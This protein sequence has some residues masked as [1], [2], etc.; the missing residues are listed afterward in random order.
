MRLGSVIVSRGVLSTALVATMFATGSIG[1]SPRLDVGSDVLWVALFEGNNLNEWTGVEGGG[2]GVS[3]TPPDMV[4]V[5]TERPHR[6]GFAAKLTIDAGSDGVQQNAGLVRKGSLPEAAY[7]SAWYYLPRTVAV[8]GF[9][10]VFKFRQRSNADDP[11]SERELFDLD[12]VQAPGGEMMLELY[13]HRVAAAAPL[14]DPSPIVPVG[15]WFHIEAFYRNAPDSQGRLTF[16]LD[17][18][19]IVDLNGPTSSTA[20]V[21]WDVVNVGLN[22]TPSMESLF[23]D[24]CAISRT[25]VGPTGIIAP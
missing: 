17:G 23:V 18:R 14:D 12:L 24:D 10:V 3:S 15:V 7:Y 19:Q 22:L 6:G 5:S 20:W 21:E 4:E 9:W 11:A 8:G 25:R 16:W 13:D 2:L 1:C